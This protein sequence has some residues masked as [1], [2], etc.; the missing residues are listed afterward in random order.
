MD[1]E[2]KSN[3]I[4]IIRLLLNDKSSLVIGSTLES[5]QRI[6]PGFL[7]P[8][9][10]RLTTVMLERHDLCHMH[11]RKFCK[12]LSEA[13][14]W[15]QIPI[16]QYLDRYTRLH[17]PDPLGLEDTKE[18]PVARIKPSSVNIDS[19]YGDALAPDTS[20]VESIQKSSVEPEKGG[21][22]MDQD[23]VFFIS[24]CKPLFSS[25]NPVV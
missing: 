25:R 5:F 9:S 6:C 20:N 15:S 21:N 7:F 18:E 14:E 12:L 1:N 19:F 4:D 3:L 10:T 17:F 13:D 11:F 8:I 23:F 16:L 22:Q 2:Q 24:S